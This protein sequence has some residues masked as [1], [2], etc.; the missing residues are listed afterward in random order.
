MSEH[1]F[2]YDVNYDDEFQNLVSQGDINP[3]CELRIEVD[4]EDLAGAPPG[5]SY[6][7]DYIFYHLRKVATAIPDVLDGDERK[8]QFYSMGDYLILHPDDG[9]VS[10]ALQ[11]PSQVE[12]WDGQSGKQI[13]KGALTRGVVDAIDEY[14]A[15]LVDVDSSL[16]A[17]E[18]VAEL[19]E[20]ADSIRETEYYK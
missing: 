10:V 9:A 13:S 19:L 16:S 15:R 5:E 18:N 3:L 12:E 17:D 4:G 8:L 14:H 11:S 20:T 6:I 7:D 2:Q 1:S